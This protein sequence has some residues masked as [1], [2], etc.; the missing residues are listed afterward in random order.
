M[1]AING[2]PCHEI[3]C[4]NANSTACNTCGDHLRQSQVYYA[5]DWDGIE[6][7]ED[8][9]QQQAEYEASLEEEE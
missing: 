7:C 6:L 4:P 9:A 8:C 3:G 5:N 2:V 1:L